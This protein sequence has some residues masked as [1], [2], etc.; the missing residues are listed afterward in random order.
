MTHTKL[1]RNFWKLVTAN[2]INRFGDAVDTIALTW[3]VY[4]LTGSALWSVFFYAS[5]QLPS[6]VIQPFQ[7]FE[8]GV[9]LS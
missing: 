5:N 3:L 9:I 6:V 7:R 4:S 8:S 2:C 1:G